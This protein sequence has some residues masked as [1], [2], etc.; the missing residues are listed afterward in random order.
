M[1][2]PA[3]LLAG[4]LLFSLLDANSKLLSGQ[5][6]LGQVIFMRYAVMLPAFLLLRAA[7]P[8]FGGEVRPIR[9]GLQLLRAASMMV[10]AAGFFLA[11]RQ[12]PLA[13]GYLVF[14]TAPFLTMALASVF[15]RE[16]VPAAAWG[17]CLLGFAGVLLAVAPKLGGGGPIGGYLAVLAGTV[18]FAVNQ[19]LNRSLR[20]QGGFAALVVWPA[21]LGLFVYGPL[22]AL[23]WVAPPPAD[24]ARLMLNGVLAG[25][26]VVCTAAAYRHADAARLGPYGYAALPAS[27]ALDFGIWG[28][29]PDAGTLL[30]GVVVVAACLMSER[31]RRGAL[32]P[33]GA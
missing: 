19:T 15:L 14:F 12:L 13:E 11:F 28:V 9:P 33:T 2:G 5:Y 29:S 24:L 25:A 10:S 22:A 23:D 26:A 32:V 21:V 18:A 17:W 16:R 6:G 4:I 1:K 30:G 8:G 31:A 3:L 7:R 27:V 20:T